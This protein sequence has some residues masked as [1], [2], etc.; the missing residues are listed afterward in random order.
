MAYIVYWL[1]ASTVTYL[2]SD[3]P[4][5]AGTA[6]VIFFALFPF[7]IAVSTMDKK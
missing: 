2:L 5:Q 3:L 4:Q 7:V 6:F 1:F